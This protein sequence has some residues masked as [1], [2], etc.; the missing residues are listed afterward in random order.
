LNFSGLGRKGFGR[1]GV[2]IKR[3]NWILACSCVIWAYKFSK[4]YC[5]SILIEGNK[6]KE[7]TQAWGKPGRSYRV[8]LAHMHDQPMQNLRPWIPQPASDWGA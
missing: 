6:R 1:E 7:K 2:E 3:K 4:A 8:S 5:G